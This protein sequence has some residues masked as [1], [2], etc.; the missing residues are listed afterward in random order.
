MGSALL[1][2]PEFRWDRYF[3]IRPSSVGIGTSFLLSLVFLREKYSE[4][5]PS[6]ISAPRFRGLAESESGWAEK[7]RVFFSLGKRSVIFFFLGKSG[8]DIRA[9]VLVGDLES[10]R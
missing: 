7:R 6:P 5:I 4:F 8:A 10:R 3:F 2:S 1:Y 9:T